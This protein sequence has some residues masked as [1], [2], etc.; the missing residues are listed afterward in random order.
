MAVTLPTL[1]LH[2]HWPKSVK[3]A[4]VCA[5]A[6]AQAA[7]H[8]K[9]MGRCELLKLGAVQTELTNYFRWYNEARP[10][11]SLGGRTPNEVYMGLAAARAGPKFES[12]PRLLKPSE[13]RRAVLNTKTCWTFQRGSSLRLKSLGKSPKLEGRA[14][15]VPRVPVPRSVMLQHWPGVLPKSLRSTSS[16]AHLCHWQSRL[17]SRPEHSRVDNPRMAPW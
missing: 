14:T 7:R 5:D 6:F 12:R 8:R 4:L 15:A 1:R 11:Q 17:V 13:R 10:H 3:S 16:T 9:I 2:R